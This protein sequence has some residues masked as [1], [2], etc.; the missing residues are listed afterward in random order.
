MLDMELPA[1]PELTIGHLENGLRYV[2]LPNK[3]PPDRMEVHLEVHAGVCALPASPAPQP[4]LESA[5]L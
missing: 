2:I 5:C 3:M 4:S 1:H